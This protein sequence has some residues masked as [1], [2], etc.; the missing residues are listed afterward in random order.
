MADTVRTYTS[1]D[2]QDC[3]CKPFI[4][5]SYTRQCVNPLPSGNRPSNGQDIG[6]ALSADPYLSN[7]GAKPG[8]YKI[9]S[10]WLGIPVWG[11][12]AAGVGAVMLFDKKGRRGRRR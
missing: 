11:W 1:Q 6:E 8:T 9:G 3:D 10:G 2:V 5:D 7:C 12:L 4:V